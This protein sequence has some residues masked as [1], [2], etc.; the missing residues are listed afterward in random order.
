MKKLLA[1]SAL[2]VASATAHATP[3]Y[4]DLDGAR[5][6]PTVELDRLTVTYD[7]Y[8]SIDLLT[9]AV[10]TRAGV[11]LIGHT[12]GGLLGSPIFSTFD[13]AFANS[14]FVSSDPSSVG[15]YFGSGQALSFGVSLSGTFSPATGVTYSTGTIDIYKYDLDNFPLTNLDPAALAVP[16]KL[17]STSFKTNKIVAGEQ[18][19]T[20]LISTG[21]D[22]TAAG[23]DHFFF[24][25]FGSLVSFEDYITNFANQ[26]R[27]TLVQTASV[28]E[29]VTAVGGGAGFVAGNV[30]GTSVV[31][32]DDHVADVRFEVPEP[33]TLAVLSLG[34][35]GLGAAGR[36]KSA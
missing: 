34:L 27:L 21:T 33:T 26:I 30:A 25:R 12:F 17:M 6:T 20:S 32:T 4:F 23:Q 18:I 5:A 16:V 8:S 7:S 1:I 24:D 15:E 35:L 11:D 3:F 2:V 13:S 31:V 22:I 36:R 14:Q 10:E 9:G 28:A 19:V 29:L